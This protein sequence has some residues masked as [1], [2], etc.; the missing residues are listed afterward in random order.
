MYRRLKKECQGKNSI[1]RLEIF[2]MHRKRYLNE[3]IDERSRGV[4]IDSAFDK[5]ICFPQREL[6][7]A[8]LFADEVSE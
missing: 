1:F 4:F 5:C 2:F 3:A 7:H 6:S 8:H